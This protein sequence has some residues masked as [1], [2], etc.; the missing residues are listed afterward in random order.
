MLMQNLGGQRKSI[1]VFSEVAYY[2]FSDGCTCPIFLMTEVLQ[3]LQNAK[4]LAIPLGNHVKQQK[5]TEATK[6]RS[7]LTKTPNF[8]ILG[9]FR[10]ILVYLGVISAHSST[11][12]YHSCSFHFIP[13]LF[14]LIPAYSSLFQYVTFCFVSYLCLVTPPT[15]HLSEQCEKYCKK[16]LCIKWKFRKIRAPDARLL[17]QK[18]VIISR[19]QS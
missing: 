12:R 7:A 2:S 3:T 13:V 19:A 10:Y 14:C 6:N 4:T 5:L 16:D 1:M 15:N 9:S 17:P 18:R 11:F 8:G